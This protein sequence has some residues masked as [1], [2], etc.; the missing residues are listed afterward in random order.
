MSF[1]PFQS[2]GV[3][4]FPR[5][6]VLVANETV[7]LPIRFDRALQALQGRGRLRLVRFSHSRARVLSECA[8]AEHDRKS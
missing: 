7:F 8:D 5:L 2:L 4:H 6:L 1:M 3:L